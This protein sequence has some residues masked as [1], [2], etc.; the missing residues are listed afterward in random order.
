MPDWS[1]IQSVASGGGVVVLC[2]MAV[3]GFGRGWW[4]PGY[5]H[6]REVKRSEKLADEV[7]QF[8]DSMDRLTDE[9]RD[10]RKRGSGI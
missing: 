4:V 3:L 5:I 10:A 6:E 9:V 7:G 1:F 2:L 8:A